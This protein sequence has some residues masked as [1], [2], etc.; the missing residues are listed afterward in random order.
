VVGEGQPLGAPL[1]SGGPYFGFMCTRQEFVRQIPGRIVGR[2]VDLDGKPGFTLTLQAR[3]QHIRRS[4]AT[5]NI[6]TNQGLLVTAA[7]LYMSLLGPEGLARV[8]ARSMRNLA[9][10]RRQL[11]AVP[12]VRA[13]FDGAHFH[14]CVL[15]LDRPVAPVLAALAREGIHGGF[16]LSR[17]YPELG[18]ALLVC[19]TE[20]K[21][22][23]DLAR[24]AQA[25]SGVLKQAA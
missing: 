23:A 12:G 22:D 16:D 18:P 9:A 8:A 10:L 2:T 19:A 5:S 1:A 21:T 15:K 7:T 13:A 14:E 6:C 25:L 20:T 4:K 3:E 17:H 24:Y 11:A